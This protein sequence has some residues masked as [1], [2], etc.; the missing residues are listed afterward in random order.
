MTGNK[1]F[2]TYPVVMFLFAQIALFTT[3]VTMAYA[4]VKRLSGQVIYRERLA[5][6]PGYI[7]KV[8][9]LDVA[10][11]DVPSR[12]IAETIIRRDRQ[13]PIPFRLDVDTHKLDPRGR[14]A[15]RAE[16][17]V[18][19]RRLFGTTSIHSFHLDHWPATAELTV[20]LMR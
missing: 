3:Q 16:I 17:W 1:K 14:Y 19:G 5:L 2:M 11:Q 7:T 8:Q 10:R 6:P 20:Q 4:S 13:A 15:L 9:L 18:K 12:I